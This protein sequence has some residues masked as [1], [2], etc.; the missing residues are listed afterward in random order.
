MQWFLLPFLLDPP[1]SYP[2]ITG[3]NTSQVLSVGSTVVI[4]CSATGGKPPISSVNL[5]CGKYQSHS[6]VIMHE[7][8]N[9]TQ[10]TVTCNVTMNNVTST[11]N[12]IICT[13][14]AIWDPDPDLPTL[15]TSITLRVAS[16]VVKQMFIFST[17]L[18]FICLFISFLLFYL[19]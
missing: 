16:M 19:W 6:D 18:F 17:L 14:R 7:S 9:M 2:I 12:G 11:D 3:Y 13:C 15:K 8:E 4:S 5:F 1:T 10:I